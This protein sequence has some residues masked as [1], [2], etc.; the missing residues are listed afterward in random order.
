M[1]RV[2]RIVLRG[3]A[4]AIFLA[5][6]ASSA[7]A[8][9]PQSDFSVAKS[10]PSPTV[11]PGND[12]EFDVD[13]TNNGPNGGAVTLNDTI[14][15]GM[16]FVSVTSAAGFSCTTPAVGAGGTVSC[17]SA[18]MTAATLAQFA[19]IF[20]IPSN[21]PTNVSYTNTATVTS[22]TDPNSSNDSSSVTV[23]TP[24]AADL[25]VSKTGPVSATNDTDVTYTIVVNNVGPDAASEVTLQDVVTGGWSFV[26]VTPAPGFSCSDPG[27]G[28]TSG[29]VFCNAGS[30][31]AGSTSTFSIV[32][33]IPPAT[34]PGTTFTNTAVVS[35]ST[36]PNSENNTST[37]AT[38]TP[39][40]PAQGDVAIGKTGPTSAAPNSDVTYTIT[41]TNLGPST[42]NNVSLTDTLPSSVP[43][44]FTMT[45]VSFNQ[46]SGPTFNCGVP[47]ATTTCSIA[48]LASGA[49]AT[50]SF[51]GHIPS[52]SPSGSD[53]TNVASV[54]A[55]NDPNSENNS[56]ATTLTVSSSDVGITKSAPATAVAGGP[57][58]NYV[59]TI[60]NSGPD[61]AT[62]P[63]F[64]DP[65]PSG[66]AFVGV[67]Q[68][69]GPSGTC[70]GG[71][72]VTC[73][74]QLL[75]NGESAQFTITVQPLA[76]DPNGSVL[77]N[78]ATV[79]SSSFDPNPNNNS[80]TATTTISAQ[81]NV[82]I[83]KSGPATAT[84]G[85]NVTYTITVTNAGPSNATN[86][87]WT[88][89][90][91]A[92]TTFVSETQT[93]GPTFNCTTGATVSC[94]IAT[95]LPA[96]SATFSVV[97]HVA[98]SVANASII[99]NTA[100]ITATTPDPNPGNNSSNVN[101]TVNTSA[102]PSI[103]KTAPA[104][105][106]AGTNMTYTVTVTN[107]GPSDA[108][109]VSWTDTLPASTTFVSET[110]TT[111]PVF[112]CTTGA[113]V[114]CN[115]ATLAAGAS[116]TFNIT[117]QVSPA[118]PQGSVISN[119]ATVT[120]S[121]ADSNPTNN[122]STASTTVGANADLSVNKT[123]PSTSQSNT[124]AIYNV[125]V[126]NG[127]PSVAANA[128]LT[129]NVPANMTFA[130][131]AQTSGPA[132]TC[133]TPAAGSPGA[134]SCTIASFAAGTTASFQFRFN[135]ISTAAAGATSTN[136]ATI[137]SITLDP[138]PANNSS[139][140]TTT[141]GTSIPTL[142]HLMLALLAAVLAAAALLKLK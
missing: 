29:T 108:T 35:S 71:S 64:S 31:A 45:F 119:T 43:A 10:T 33:H 125:T 75:L 61:A 37:A 141:I 6:I 63:G 15:A 86:V 8:Q 51:V 98:S 122:T 133:T 89:T 130:S 107:A 7:L 30:L 78:T 92:G 38:T 77:S 34:P 83:V 48:S 42:A 66:V 14:P 131:A 87:S 67:V 27:A 50:F 57:A 36:D 2:P 129:D 111:G 96:A 19:I 116:A 105:A 114:S 84:A 126:A 53:Y 97:A 101:T 23:N 117:V 18:S 95:L 68:D 76:S 21:G 72:T 113:V 121:T 44:G 106:A 11:F 88:D 109:N 56:S 112:T 5:G 103:A 65:L 132:F 118:A 127:G 22:A 94:S 99:S 74:V 110:Q 46:T 90:L 80:S 104:A 85:S 69:T 47:A 115:I 3:L 55:A 81:A 91:P 17:S 58:F 140:V 102:D 12:V 135:V 82:S 16:T 93:S 136:T 9:S 28:A 100:V 120:S 1:N 137:S 123:G 60:S 49:S 13:V 24:P 59:I 39:G 52:G 20:H 41:V 128:T 142:S 138:N 4:A 134:I 26:S 40:A 32:F 139:S 79:S 73:N 70:S 62:D 54:S 25:S 124:V